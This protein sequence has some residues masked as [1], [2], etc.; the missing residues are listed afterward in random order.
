MYI[1]VNYCVYADVYECVCVYMC[2]YVE[3]V[4]FFCVKFLEALRA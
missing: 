4:S 1:C 2:V 3:C